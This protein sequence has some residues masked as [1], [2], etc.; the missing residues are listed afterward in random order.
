MGVCVLSHTPAL[1]FVPREQAEAVGMG[2]CPAGLGVRMDGWWPIISQPPWLGNDAGMGFWQ[3]CNLRQAGNSVA[4]A[5][6]LRKLRYG[7]GGFHGE[8]LL[9]RL[10]VV[11]VSEVQSDDFYLT[12]VLWG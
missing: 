6:G 9:R 11:L 12:A 4:G 5:Q 3:V 10:G 1:R 2:C 7:Q 8:R